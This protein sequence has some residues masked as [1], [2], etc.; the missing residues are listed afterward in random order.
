ME[1]VWDGARHFEIRGLVERA[2]KD[3]VDPGVPANKRALA[4]AALR[5]ADFA[6]A[7]PVVRKVLSSNPPSE[8]QAACILTLSSF[9]HPDV[10]KALLAQ[11]SAYS[12]D[13]RAKAIGALLARKD[14]IPALLD[15]IES[16]QVPANALET[17]ARNRLLELSDAKLLER[18]RKALKAG[19][20]DRGKVLAS[21]QD[22]LAL[23]GNVDHGKQVFE[24]ACAKCHMPRRQGGRIG[25]D[26]TGINMKSKEELLA[27][28]L[29][30]SAAIEAR[31][32]NY[33]VTTKDGRMY[34]GVLAG[35]TPGAITLR[36]GSEEDV[37]LPRAA[38]QEIRSS[39]IS[40]MPEDLEKT[41]SKQD[42]ADVIAY[43]RGGL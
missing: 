29:D 15:A 18:A 21:F 16:N 25:P 23:R 35:E 3:A 2:A 17:G 37:T 9:D 38:V 6:R 10:A 30:P 36:G 19:G 28:I 20:S 31:Y 40:L 39:N 22:A 13:A 8:L 12:P 14:R 33:L 4:I 5:G 27:A 43:L 7:L 42:L 41:L 24:D 32:V 11:W 34:D 1:A 26:L